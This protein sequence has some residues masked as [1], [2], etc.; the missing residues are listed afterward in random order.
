MSNYHTCPE[1]GAPV[2]V[3]Y[4][5]YCSKHMLRL[6]RYGSVTGRRLTG[7]ELEAHRK[8]IGRGL[9]ARHDTPPVNAALETAADW[10]NY[11]PERGWNVQLTIQKHM[12]RL[13]SGGVS[14]Y[15]FLVEV[16]SVFAIEMLDEGRFYSVKEANYMVA[17]QVLKLR[18]MN[19]WRPTGKVLNHLGGELRDSLAFFAYQLTREAMKADT[20]KVRR[21][22]VM[23]SG[24]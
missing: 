16:C 3:G 7:D 24:W 17:R 20:V 15:E 21:R 5:R 9:A 12:Q 11:Q 19:T 1:C 13:A 8:I 22:K 2:H 6:A 18:S 4:S 23:L 14:P 10:L